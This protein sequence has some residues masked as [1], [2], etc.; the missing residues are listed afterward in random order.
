[1]DPVDSEYGSRFLAVFRTATPEALAERLRVEQGDRDP[2]AAI[3]PV[4]FRGIS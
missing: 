4:M 1:M 2:L 3:I